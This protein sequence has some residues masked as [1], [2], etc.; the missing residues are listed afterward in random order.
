[1]DPEYA[2]VIGIDDGTYELLPEAYASTIDDQ[3]LTDT[4]NMN[5]GVCGG[6]GGGGGGGNS[7]DD[8]NKLLPKLFEQMFSNLEK[9]K[10]FEDK[11]DYMESVKHYE[12]ALNIVDKAITIQSKIVDGDIRTLQLLKTK[13]EEFNEKRL[14]LLAM[15][16]TKAEEEEEALAIALSL[17][18]TNQNQTTSSLSSSS[19]NHI[20]NNNS[21]KVEKINHE[22]LAK[23]SL[24]EALLYDEKKRSEDAL[25]LYIQ[26]AEQYLTALDQTCKYIKKYTQNQN[27]N[28]SSSGIDIN[29]YLEREKSLR[30]SAAQVLDRIEIIKKNLHEFE[31]Q[32]MS[33]NQASSNEASSGASDEVHTSKENINALESILPKPASG[34]TVNP[35]PSCPDEAYGDY[36]GD[37]NNNNNNSNNSRSS[38]MLS[39]LEL[40]VLRRTS[41]IYGRLFLPWI[42]DQNNEKFRYLTKW[43]DVEGGILP[44]SL[45]QQSHLGRWRRPHEFVQ[46][47]EPVMISQVCMYVYICYIS[48]FY[49]FS[50]I[51]LI[52]NLS[53]S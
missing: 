48:Y 11:K 34:P 18:S 38:T 41:T 2:E 20:N 4:E 33:L 35:P 31:H 51:S 8:V 46:G 22:S 53:F 44:L 10:E 17:T 19:S 42:N 15:I 7:D 1:M 9:A 14:L 47:G 32:E 40:D 25:P 27:Q 5:N 12:I 36:S 30:K 43:E 49:S 39:P 26:S 28:Q 13:K 23:L 3:T 45:K 52:F 21:V 50:N 24:M 16:E 6:S 29:V 37:D